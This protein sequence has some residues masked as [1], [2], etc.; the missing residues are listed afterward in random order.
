MTYRHQ[1]R[2]NPIVSLH[3]VMIDLSDPGVL[4]K[5]AMAGEDPDGPGPWQTTL[6]PV[7]DIASREGFDL[8]VN[9]NFFMIR[10]DPATTRKKYEYGAWASNIGWTM[11][12]GLLTSISRINDWPILWVEGQR[13][14]KIGT[15]QRVPPA[16]RQI[17]TGN[18]YVLKAGQPAEPFT[19]VMAVRHPRTV[20]G[21]DRDGT[22]LTILIVDGRRFGVS[23][24]MTGAELADEMKNLGCW[25]AINL[26]GGGSTTL[27]MRNP[28]NGEL[29]VLNQPSDGSE[30]P[31]SGALGITL[32]PNPPATQPHADA[33]KDPP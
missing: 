10:N 14:V 4:I 12:D 29:V 33:A 18:C 21:I 28:D 22:Q 5:V 32:K 3:V 9:A 31:V 2:L 6:L 30:R 15:P 7:R 11:S 19:G 13:T 17:V 1:R 23:V 24:G 8:A 26:D 20:V 27:V 25:D 16:A